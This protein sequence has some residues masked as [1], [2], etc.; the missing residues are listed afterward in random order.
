[1]LLKTK[2]TIFNACVKS[3]LLY[4]SES[5]FVSAAITQKLQTYVNRCLR[6]ILRIWWPR[7][8]RNERLWQITNQQ[9]IE[10][11][12]IKRK[13]GWLGHTLRKPIGEIAHAALEWNPQG[14]RNRGRPKSTWRR[15]IS[16]ETGK[17]FSE[18]RAIA[19]NRNNW[20]ILVD[21]LSS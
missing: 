11:Q 16:R 9:P 4:G 14:R 18:L 1:M 12:I 13:Y 17:S 2:I 10:K 3:V 8:I 7:T 15:S 20:K 21:R 5:W 19:R 6:Q